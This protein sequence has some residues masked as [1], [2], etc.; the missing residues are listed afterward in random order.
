MKKKNKKI[1]LKEGKITLFFKEDRMIIELE[2]MKSYTR[3]AKIELTLEQM[4]KLFSGLYNT[5]CKISLN[6]INRIDKKH[7]HREF[8]IELNKNNFYD[9]KTA[10]RLTM[11]LC[12]KGWIPD[13]YFDSQGSFFIENK[14]YYARSIIRRYV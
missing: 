13:L 5:P 2:D 6:N 3:F 4:G 11:K 12:P 10:K 1:K 9:K 7:E 8:I 14:K